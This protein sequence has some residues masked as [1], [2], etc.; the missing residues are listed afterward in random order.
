M[1]TR[2]VAL[3][4]LGFCATAVGEG[5][6]SGNWILEVYH[7][8]EPL[9]MTHVILEASGDGF[10]M[11]DVDG[12]SL[13]DDIQVVDGNIEFQH[14]VLEELCRLTWQEDKA[15][16]RGTCPPGNELEF[17]EGLTISLRTP[18][19]GGGDNDEDS[20]DSGDSAN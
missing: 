7:P 13:F 8:S 9:E 16:W 19:A 1:M 10:T 5:L 20:S 12:D 18:K 17:E 6:E 2:C 3:L 14:P 4:L 15:S 11:L